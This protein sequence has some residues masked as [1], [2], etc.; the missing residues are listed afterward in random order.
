V[1]FVAHVLFC[2]QIVIVVP[3]TLAC[4]EVNLARR[5]VRALTEAASPLPVVLI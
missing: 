3:L 4:V 2:I 1:Y 5:R